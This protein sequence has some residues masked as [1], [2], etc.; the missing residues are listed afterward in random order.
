M[1]K[2]TTIAEYFDALAPDRK[3]PMERLTASIKA[4]LPDGFEEVLNYGMPSWVVP[5]SIYEAGYHA[6]P[7][8]PL[9]FLG[10][11]S[12]KSH[13]ALYHMGVY[14]TQELMEWF[15]DEYPAHSKTKLD[16]GKSCIR[17]RK[18]DNIPYALIGELCSKM[19][20]QEWIDVYEEQVKKR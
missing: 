5:H 19:S 14:A 15:L 4:N 3:E 2:P 8:L 20:P 10:L 16:M 18:V 11:A 13:I 1:G 7:K 9:P 17:F 6:N 12:Q